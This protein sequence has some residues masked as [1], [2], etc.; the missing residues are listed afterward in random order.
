MKEPVQKV[1]NALSD[2]QAEGNFSARQTAEF[3]DLTITIK[4]VGELKFPLKPAKAR[5]LI[6]RAKPAKYGF[7]D[8]TILDPEVRN[9]W[10]IPKSLVK[11]DKRKWN[12]TLNPVLLEL[13]K[14]LGLT[15]QQHFKAQLHNFLIY[16]KG[17][18]FQSHQDTEKQEN[19]VATLVILLPSR[20]R[21]GTLSIENQSDFKHYPSTSTPEN[22]LTFI[23]FYA[24]C[25][26]QVKKV[27]E[28]YRVA[29]TYN[30]I[31]EN[32]GDDTAESVIEK[33]S[34]RSLDKAI[35]HYFSQTEPSD[36]YY[37]R[38][39]N[40]LVYLLDHQYSPKGIKWG[41]LK[42]KD[43]IRV[44]ALCETAKQNDLEIFLTLADIQETWDCQV[45]YDYHSQYGGW[46]YDDEDEDDLDSMDE[47][48]IE[49]HDLI[50]DETIIR[51]WTD[52]TG[53]QIK[54]PEL[55]VRGQYVG[56][57][58][59]SNDCKPF[60]SE[61]EG[62]MG[63]WGNTMEYWY[64]R[65]AIV[66]WLKED[67]YNVLLE[68]NPTK[69]I[70]ELLRMAQDKNRK[71]RVTE[72]VNHL[73]NDWTGLDKS[74]KA[75]DYNRVLKLA[76][77][78][79]N[80]DDADLLLA[81]LDREA[82]TPSSISHIIQLEK[83]YGTAWCIKLLEQWYAGKGRAGIGLRTSVYTGSSSTVD[84]LEKI[85]LKLVST[86]TTSHA[87]LINWFVNHQWQNLQDANESQ[88]KS[89]QAAELEERAKERFKQI[90]ALIQ[91]CLLSQSQSVHNE[92]IHYMM[93]HQSLYSSVRLVD[94][95]TNIKEEFQLDK[96]YQSE[97]FS[98]WMYKELS[99]T[100][101]DR[102]KTEQKKG[103]RKSGDWSIVDRNICTCHDCLDLNDF[104]Q[105]SDLQKK[106][107]PINK[108]R[109]FH[110]H[111][112][113][114]KMRIPVTHQTQRTGS[115]HKLVLIKTKELFLQDKIR[116]KEINKALK[117]LLE[118]GLV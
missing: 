44:Q 21:G 50:A 94:L 70:E 87:E 45:E 103:G 69:V 112:I 107:W 65:A 59:A 104:L 63:N 89:F 88:L 113:I 15:K 56:W 11:I 26:H 23:A 118:S 85:I 52:I 40:K 98:S 68:F 99:Q 18:F 100:L 72:T 108:D 25:P 83:V 92:I 101:S 90:K 7:R 22:K 55:S 2:I 1:I 77:L 79:N 27:T 37:S 6:K 29:M 75:T 12:K 48:S 46:G 91:S 111:Q 51:H 33:Q 93:K 49:L 58:K 42:S 54:Y 24:D 67:H 53:K 86:Q 30:L 13:E 81:K 60:E 73:L 20:Y 34:Q 80:A 97:S 105:S 62:Y 95:L 39:C 115:P 10:E 76:C 3:T 117:T 74:A 78:I 17:Q 66:L 32:S 19:M 96:Q 61:Y 5:A 47:D 14:E 38:Q 110:I 43:K 64:H 31:L 28:G 84:S 16:E 36:S 102:L 4:E 116:I 114:T 71:D 9:V 57:T 106:I 41:N 82:L 8:Q 109:R 35:A